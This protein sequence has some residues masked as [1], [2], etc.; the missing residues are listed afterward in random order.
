MA[1]DEISWLIAA[2]VLRERND[3]GE[4]P[5]DG[6]ERTPDRKFSDQRS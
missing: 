3:D 5:A 4:Y 1:I 2:H 6:N